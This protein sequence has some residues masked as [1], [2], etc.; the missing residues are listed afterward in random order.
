MNNSDATGFDIITII[1]V[2]G[3]WCEGRSRNHS[4]APMRSVKIL[5]K[6]NSFEVN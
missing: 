5:V 3:I 2:F 4:I 6:V 1:G